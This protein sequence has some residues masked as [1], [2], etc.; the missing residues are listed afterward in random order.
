ME[1]DVFQLISSHTWENHVCPSSGPNI[2]RIFSM[3]FWFSCVYQP[4]GTTRSRAWGPGEVRRTQ[5]AIFFL[6]SASCTSELKTPGVSMMTSSLPCHLLLHF[7]QTTVTNFAAGLEANTFCARTLLPVALFPAP[8][9]PTKT[10]LNCESLWS[11]VSSPEASGNKSPSIRMN[12][13]LFLQQGSC[14]PHTLLLSGP[15]P[16]RDL[17]THRSTTEGPSTEAYWKSSWSLMFPCSTWGRFK[18]FLGF[19]GA[20]YSYL[21]SKVAHGSGNRRVQEENSEL[22]WVAV[23]CKSNA[24]SNSKTDFGTSPWE[25]LPQF[26]FKMELLFFPSR[27]QVGGF[28][29]PSHPHRVQKGCLGRKTKRCCSWLYPSP[30]N[31]TSHA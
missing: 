11:W 9:L 8:V 28:Y 1:T 29:N 24:G 27:S 5:W 21:F 25:F 13:W 12:L 22:S 20:S 6:M 3:A 15:P 10:S 23:P 4:S 14:S 17:C 7:L 30:D 2:C 16:V 19:H 18:D 31:L 26:V